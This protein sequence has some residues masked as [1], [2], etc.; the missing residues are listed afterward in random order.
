MRFP[1]S[2]A[3]GLAAAV[4]VLLA[5]TTGSASSADRPLAQLDADALRLEK[6]RSEVRVLQ[7]DL[8]RPWW[9]DAAVVSS[10]TAAIALLGLLVTL[11]TQGRANRRQ[12]DADRA[13]A[14]SETERLLSEQFGLSGGDR[15]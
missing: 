5:G 6:L 15:R 11:Y 2:R 10:S 7:D 13:Q 3:Y 4:L 14:Q 8:A 1:R 9:Q 12:R